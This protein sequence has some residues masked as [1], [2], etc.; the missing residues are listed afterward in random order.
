MR[1]QYWSTKQNLIC[2][3]KR[4]EDEHLVA[5][6]AELDAKLQAYESVKITCENLLRCIERYQDFI[7][8][9]SAEE[10]AL[11]RFLKSQGKADKTQAGKI[12][13]AVGRAQSYTAQ[14]RLSL[15]LPLV[16]LYQ[17]LE[18]F[19]ERAVVDCAKTVEKVEEQ[20]TKYRGS[21]LWMKNVSEQLNPDTYR[22]LEKFRTVQAQVKKN[23]DKFDKVKLDCL[24]KIDLLSASRCN[25]FSQILAEYQRSLLTFWDKTVKAYDVIIDS[26]KG[27]QYYEFKILKSLT[28]PSLRPTAEEE[29]KN[30]EPVNEENSLISLAQ[31]EPS[32]R[33][34]SM[35]NFFKDSPENEKVTDFSS[36]NDELKDIFCDSN[37]KSQNFSRSASELSP[38]LKENNENILDILSKNDENVVDPQSFANQWEKA[39]GLNGL[40]QSNE[41]PSPSQ[42]K[43][44]PTTLK[45]TENTSKDKTD[46]FNMFADVDP[47]QNPE[48]FGKAIGSAGDGC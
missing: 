48:A 33:S 5:S 1:Q 41:S 13:A 32:K 44:T 17:D 42:K 30:N 28:D 6:D 18:V 24:Q 46:F 22:Q 23:K 31:L 29:K 34:D 9:L 37:I 47:L 7:C 16:R 8:D 26:F 45:S 35:E 21:L 14:Q 3:L 10:N 4:K 38:L 15:R 40:N 25:L 19:V 27:Y 43:A 36:L 11:G 2:K 20:R 39:F 12:M